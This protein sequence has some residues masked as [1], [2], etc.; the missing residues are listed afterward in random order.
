M[1]LLYRGLMLGAALLILG[2]AGRSTAQSGDTINDYLQNFDVLLLYP[3]A[4]WSDFV[5]LRPA[6]DFERAVMIIEQPESGFSQRVELNLS[7]IAEVT[8]PYTDFS[9][10]WNIPIE[11]PPRLYTNM[12]VRWEFVLREGRTDDLTTLIPFEDSR[13]NWQVDVDG[14]VR[15]ALPSELNPATLRP[16]VERIYDLMRGHT[17]QTVQVGL[18]LFDAA[19]PINP[20]DTDNDGQSVVRTQG[21]VREVTLACDP[22]KTLALHTASGYTP[23]QTQF[24]TYN[25]A[26]EAVSGALVERLYGA[27]LSAAPEWFRYGLGLFYAPTD[28]LNYLEEAQRAARV[29]GLVSL[30]APPPDDPIKRAI[31]QAQSYGM[32]LYMAEQI[33]VDA[34]FELAAS[35]DTRSLADAYRAS[36][37]QPLSAVRPAWR[38][39]IYSAQARTAYTYNPY[40]ETTP[41]PT[42]TLS[43]TPFPPT[44]TRTPT[45]TATPTITPTVT[46]V[47][48]PTPRP[49]NTPGPTATP[50]FTP[51]PAGSFSI[52]SGG[53]SAESAP[54]DN[55][56][57]VIGIGI[58]ALIALAAVTAALLG[59]RRRSRRK[60][61]QAS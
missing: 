47:L 23:L 5:L 54:T 41:T 22:A 2:T 44:N 29:G 11:N 61:D 39:W 52:P 8:D 26:L 56:L 10:V 32:V 20:C 3:E 27:R 34:L 24:I 1:R 15:L 21:L 35:L 46:G 25:G 53:G 17:G 36:A 57:T 42:A 12:M 51:R 43:A 31:W 50:T 4:I 13:A 9:Y 48:S 55:Q 33:G 6:S 60:D 49:S 38:D 18:A 40:L 30:D 16:D 28:K 14:S 58:G 45:I 59:I 19:M 7:E 37:D